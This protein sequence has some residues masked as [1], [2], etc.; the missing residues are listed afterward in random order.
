MFSGEKEENIGWSSDGL[1]YNASLI[2]T[3]ADGDSDKKS[4]VASG[5]LLGR[6]FWHLIIFIIRIALLMMRLVLM[7][8]LFLPVFPLKEVTL[9]YQL[10][11]IM[12]LEM[13]L[14][15][16]YKLLLPCSL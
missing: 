13:M 1:F 12:R 15:G 10:I 14:F 9:A 8:M 5:D 6:E 3:N 16:G 4:D 11:L 2:I 7:N